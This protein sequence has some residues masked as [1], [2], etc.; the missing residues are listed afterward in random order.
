[1]LAADAPFVVALHRR[2]HVARY[3]D[4]PSEG[5]VARAL[6]DPSRL[7]LLIEVDARPAGMMLVGLTAPWLIELQRLVIAE[8]GR[9]LGRAAIRW[10]VQ[11]TFDRRGAHRLWLEVRADNAPARGLYESSGFTH[12]GT[13]RD[14]YRD[15]QSGAYSDLCAYG[16]LGQ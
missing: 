12:E 15:A 2:S 8:P 11:E 14:G 10:L 13:W 3:V 4:A 1:M 7:S 9:G 5:Q 16:L 6:D